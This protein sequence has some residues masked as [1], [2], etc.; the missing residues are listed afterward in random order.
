MVIA[1]GT[2]NTHTHT[3]THTHTQFA[4]GISINRNQVPDIRMVETW[5]NCTCN[6]NSRRN[7]KHTHT[8]TQFAEGISITRNQVT[9]IRMVETWHNCTWKYIQNRQNTKP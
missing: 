8:H 3:H 9:D 7:R 6:G 1:E 5:H 4:E 2:E